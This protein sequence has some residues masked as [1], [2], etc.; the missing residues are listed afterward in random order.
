MKATLELQPYCRKHSGIGTYV[1]EPAKQLTDGNRLEF[2]RNLVCFMGRNENS[3][4]LNMAMP[5]QG[6]RIFPYG[7]V[8]GEDFLSPARACSQARQTRACFQLYCAASHQRS[9]H[10][11]DP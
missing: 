3:E 2:C 8:F 7:T 1:Y 9:G 5:I 10:Y 4:S 6:N 11:H